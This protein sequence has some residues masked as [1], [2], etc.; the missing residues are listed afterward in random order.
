M[1]VSE[2]ISMIQKESKTKG[3]LKIQSHLAEDIQLSSANQYAHLP[4]WEKQRGP[5]PTR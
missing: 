3:M 4:Q 1:A 5:W 2:R